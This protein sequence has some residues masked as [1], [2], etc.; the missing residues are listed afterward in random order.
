MFGH[1]RARQFWRQARSGYSDE[2]GDYID[3]LIGKGEAAE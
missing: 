1:D 3:G 2:L